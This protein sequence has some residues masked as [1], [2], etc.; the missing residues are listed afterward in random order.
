MEDTGG[1]TNGIAA[2]TV[3]ILFFAIACALIFGSDNG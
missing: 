3:I 2:L 1:I